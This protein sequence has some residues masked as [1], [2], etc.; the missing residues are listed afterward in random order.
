M[1]L[2]FVLILW[3]KWRET[4]QKAD[5]FN[6]YLQHKHVFAFCYGRL[7]LQIQ[8]IST[9]GYFAEMFQIEKHK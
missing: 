5:L 2:I 1:A 8:K 7:Y 9:V 6:E 3:K 4:W